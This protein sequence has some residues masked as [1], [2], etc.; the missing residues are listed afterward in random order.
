MARV[1]KG[2]EVIVIAG[3]D[4]GKRGVVLTVMN[5]VNKVI[6]L[7]GFITQRPKRKYQYDKTTHK[8]KSITRSSRR[9]NRKRVTDTPV[10]CCNMESGN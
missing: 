6:V 8:R 4:K 3:R 7:L 9:H 2:D 1:K 5:D 10:E